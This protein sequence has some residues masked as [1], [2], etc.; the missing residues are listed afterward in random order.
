VRSVCRGRVD[1]ARG[2]QD[3]I[4]ANV[5]NI[6]VRCYTGMFLNSEEKE[7]CSYILISSQIVI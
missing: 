1:H 6:N 2:G 7:I 3:Q 5:F 4:D